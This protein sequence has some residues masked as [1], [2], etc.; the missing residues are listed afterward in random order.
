MEAPRENM[1]AL[2]R[3]IREKS[4]LKSSFAKYRFSPGERK[5]IKLFILKCRRIYVANIVRKIVHVCGEIHVS[6]R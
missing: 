1:S 6:G 2:V 5:E 3:S 4:L